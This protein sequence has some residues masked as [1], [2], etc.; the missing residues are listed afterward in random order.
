VAADRDL[1]PETERARVAARRQPRHTHDRSL[2]PMEESEE[3]VISYMDMVTVLMIVFLGMVA[4]LGMDGRLSNPSNE[5]REATKQVDKALASHPLPSPFPTLHREDDADYE[6]PPPARPPGQGGPAERG[7]TLTVA[8]SSPAALSPAAQAWLRKLEAAGLPPDVDITLKD[9]KVAIVVRDRILFPS[10]SATLQ[11]AAVDLL[12]TLAPSLAAL[13]GSI[14]VEGHSDDVAISTVR[15]PSNWEL[16]AARAAAVVRVLA[17]LGLPPE[18]LGALG[19]ADSRP[20]TTD[21]TRRAENRR[22]EIVVDTDAV[23]AKG[24]AR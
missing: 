24:V 8:G 20:L 5:E 1:T 13:P 4:I 22:V 11:P 12:R 6:A 16:S 3:W 18:R 19:L 9:R 15:F 2:E 10:G 21:P 14:T 17:T 7:S 23:T